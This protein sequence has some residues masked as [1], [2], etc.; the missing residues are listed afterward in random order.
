MLIGMHS[1]RA[2]DMW[3]VLLNTLIDDI[4]ALHKLELSL[5]PQP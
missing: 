1:L 5:I 3:P 4:S 2:A